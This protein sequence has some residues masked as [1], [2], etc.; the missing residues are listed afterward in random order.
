MLQ[1]GVVSDAERAGSKDHALFRVAG[2]H[3]WS[4][5]PDK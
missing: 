5:T 4:L 2:G 3:Y 1:D